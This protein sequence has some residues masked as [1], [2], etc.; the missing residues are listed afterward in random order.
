[1]Y[2]KGLI[3]RVVV[4]LKRILKM[5]VGVLMILI[6]LPWHLRLLPGFLL[7]TIGGWTSDASNPPLREHIRARLLVGVL[8]LLNVL[9]TWGGVVLFRSAIRQKQQENGA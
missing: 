3:G 1:M 2:N 8:F 7:V 9:L 5:L 6:S 4:R